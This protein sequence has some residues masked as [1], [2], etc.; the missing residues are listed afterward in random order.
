MNPITNLES[1]VPQLPSERWNP[2][3]SYVRH[4][5]RGYAQTHSPELSYLAM[6]HMTMFADWIAFT[7]VADLDKTALSVE[8]IDAYT[9][10]RSS[11]VQPVVAERERKVLRTLAGLAPVVEK[12]AVST[13]SDPLAP[14][15]QQEQ[16]QLRD[17]AMW[18]GLPSRTLRCTA[19]A[20]LGL[21]CGLT[22]EEML[23]VRADDI[24]TLSDGMLGVRVTDKRERT[25]PVL[26]EW[27]DELE[28]VK[29]EAT[30]FVISPNAES[31]QSAL[32][33]DSIKE[34]RGTIKPTAQRMRNTWLLT[35]ID[36][37]VPLPVLMKAA[38]LTSPDSLRRLIAAHAR[39]PAPAEQLTLLRQAKAVAA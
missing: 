4:S 18:Q 15:T 39:V 34:S 31:R 30:G 33:K 11:E 35:H 21:G 3:A 24:T 20:A 17:W 13:V 29:A 32:L 14:Y 23:H 12:R 25:V 2:I 16:S 5:V 28:T 1:F 26:T 8:V 36:N 6:M 38:G 9:A 37:S 10:H 22:S 27:N 19:I 7:G